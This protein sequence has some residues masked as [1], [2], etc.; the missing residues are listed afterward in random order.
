MMAMH[1]VPG[2]FLNSAL[3]VVG[4]PHLPITSGVWIL[5]YEFFA[6]DFPILSVLIELTLLDG[7]EPTARILTQD[8]RD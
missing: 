5:R 1:E 7:A 6:I 3:D 8:V 2:V 4:P